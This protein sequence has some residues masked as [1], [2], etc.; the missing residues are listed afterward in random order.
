MLDN[1]EGDSVWAVFENEDAGL[2]K[3]SDKESDVNEEDLEGE[4]FKVNVA[5]ED[6]CITHIWIDE[7]PIDPCDSLLTVE[8]LSE[9][10][11]VEAPG[12]EEATVNVK[13]DIAATIKCNDGVSVADV[14]LYDSGST[15]HLSP[16]CDDFQNFENLPACVFKTVNAQ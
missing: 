12:N 14:E 4:S 2:V 9:E 8:M 10:S 7:V 13:E 15:C 1:D 5:D 11:D 6:L 16:C 3:L